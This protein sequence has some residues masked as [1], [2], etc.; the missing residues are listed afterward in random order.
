MVERRHRAEAAGHCR[1]HHTDLGA[2][3]ARGRAA[4]ASSSGGFSLHFF[5]RLAIVMRAPEAGGAP[6]AMGLCIE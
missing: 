1:S 5:A 6:A 2:L 4:R 3:G